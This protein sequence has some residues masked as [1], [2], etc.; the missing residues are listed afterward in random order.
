[1]HTDAMKFTNDL[2]ALDHRYRAKRSGQSPIEYAAAVEVYRPARRLS[3]WAV[4][5]T[6]ALGGAAAILAGAMT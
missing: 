2:S 6:L 5:I 4:A 3:G 1:M